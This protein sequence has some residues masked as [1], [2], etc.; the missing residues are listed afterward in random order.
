MRIPAVVCPDTVT[1]LGG[2]LDDYTYGIYRLSARRRTRNLRCTP[3]CKARACRAHGR[4]VCPRSCPRP[5]CEKHGPTRMWEYTLTSLV[6]DDQT[7]QNRGG[8]PVLT[9][10]TGENACVDVISYLLGMLEA[11]AELKHHRARRQ[12]VD[13]VRAELEGA[14]RA[15]G[16]HYANHCDLLARGRNAMRV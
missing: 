6:N 2:Y 8:D 1:V 10:F 13:Y 9:T 12:Y 3:R 7:R 4:S 5:A 11:K 15:S 14:L 16:E